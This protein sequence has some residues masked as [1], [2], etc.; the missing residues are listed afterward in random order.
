MI[1]SLSI[2][3][4]RLGRFGN[5]LFTI[6]G[7]IGIA[8]RSGQPFGF[9]KWI[10]QD[11]AN[12]GDVP[13][14][15]QQFFENPLPELPYGLTFQDY[16]YLWEYRDIYLPRD[17]WNIFAHLQSVK[18]FEHCID[19]VRYYFRM[20]DE[21]EQNDFVAIHYRAGD[22]IDNPE[23]YHPRC[24]R[25][26]YD[27]AMALFPNEK[28]LVFSD[29][30]V[31]AKE[32][33]PEADRVFVSQDYLSDFKLMKSCKSFICANSS[34][35]HMAALLGT[36]PGKKIVMPRKWFGSQAGITFDTLYPENAIIL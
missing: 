30:I 11:N 25:E 15:M 34:Y 13:H 17:S 7:V 23:A 26:Y 1:T 20:K 18:W 32:R 21:P 31:E 27:Q 9:P 36:H 3:T 22:Y 19:E 4:G 2:N 29:N 6:A 10:N 12:F 16:P 5:Q 14:E 28:F 35:S 33:L 8:R 24:S